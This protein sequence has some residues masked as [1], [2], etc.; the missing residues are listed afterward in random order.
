MKSLMENWG[1]KLIGFTVPRPKK[2]PGRWTLLLVE[3]RGKVIS[4]GPYQGLTITSALAIL[5][6]V[7]FAIGLYFLFGRET[8]ENKRL[9]NALEAS[10]Q[11]AAVLRDEKE[12]LMVRLVLAESKLKTGQDKSTDEKPASVATV[13]ASAPDTSTR[14]PR[15]V[16]PQDIHLEDLIVLNEPGNR[17]LRIEFRLKKTGTSSETVSGY[18]FL[19]LKPDKIEQKLWVTIPP[20]PLISG[21]PAQ[22]RGGQYFS[23]ARFKSMKFEHKYAP[24]QDRFQYV[25][26]FIYGT[27]EKLLLEKE[28]PVKMQNVPPVSTE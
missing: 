25:A 16:E 20:V 14:S 23:I 24:G 1:K 6:V 13:A 19:I 2:R 9:Q 12:R 26:I 10:R 17:R 7:A 22:V 8:G 4:I 18:A 15:D 27:D 3:D 5:A 28:L 21:K 11:N